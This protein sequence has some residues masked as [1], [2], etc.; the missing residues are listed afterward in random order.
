MGVNEV[1]FPCAQEVLDELER[2]LASRF[3]KTAKTQSQILRYI[4]T[5]YLA[6]EPI[7]GADIRGEIPG[8]YNIDSHK[9]RSHAHIIRKKLRDYYAG[10]G[11][12]NLVL[13]YLPPGPSYTPSASYRSN[14]EGLLRY[15]QALDLMRRGS[16]ESLNDAEV[17]LG[18]VTEL[19]PSFLPCW[20]SRAECRLLL[21]IAR[22]LFD[23]PEG[24]D[25]Q[26]HAAGALDYIGGLDE[27][28]GNKL[29]RMHLIAGA[30]HLL[31]GDAKAAEHEFEH[32]LK[33]DFDRTSGSLWYAAYLFLVKKDQAAAL[34]VITGQFLSLP[35]SLAARILGS[36]FLHCSG[37]H[38]MAIRTAADRYSRQ[39]GEL[40]EP[41]LLGLAYLSLPN[42]EFAIRAFEMTSEIGAD[43]KATVEHYH[44]ADFQGREIERFPGF[45]ILALVKAGKR[46]EAEQRLADLRKR[47]AV[48]AF[49]L[50]IANM[51]LG[52]LG[53]A[54][55]W[56]WR[57]GIDGHFL[58]YWL[59]LLPC[60][61]PLTRHP[62]FAELKDGILSRLKDKASA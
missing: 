24:W 42:F 21:T 60:A 16:R 35:E 62:R 27:Q 56:Y 59:D 37:S 29:P 52:R 44:G 1:G 54:L 11:K 8:H 57:C 36:L 34:A 20:V 28:V 33:H 9:E 46:I 26:R 6:G 61:D 51:A 30:A 48:K 55:I 38:V 32:A 7:K 4:V 45:M 40:Y 58:A 39:T 47:K 12:D 17:I 31:R 3:F 14:A 22:T 2:L 23:I 43:E 10:E 49:D 25:I 5:K 15:R 18:L 50:M 53:R 19:C 41:L 13:I